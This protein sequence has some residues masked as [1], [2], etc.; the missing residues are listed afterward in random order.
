MANYEKQENELKQSIVQF[1]NPIDTFVPIDVNRLRRSLTSANDIQ[2]GII[3][4]NFVQV[5]R[6]EKLNKKI[7]GEIHVAFPGAGEKII[8]L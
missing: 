7:V 2:C 6:A 1:E 5:I 4:R 3:L 8:P